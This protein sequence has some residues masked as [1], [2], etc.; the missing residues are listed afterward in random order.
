[1]GMCLSGDVRGGKQAV[2][3]GVVQGRPT[4]AHNNNN[5][6][7]SDS[8][9]DAIDFFFRSRGDHAL[10]TQIEVDIAVFFTQKSWDFFL[11]FYF[12]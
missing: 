3:H 12:I 9:N 4:E 1:M 11:F 2:G 8:H 5:A 6:G 10:F 7:G